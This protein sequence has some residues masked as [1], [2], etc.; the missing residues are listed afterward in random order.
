MKEHELL[1]AMLPEGLEPYFEIED[2]QKTEK[3][4]R[5]VLMEKNEVPSDLP[6]KFSS[7]KVINTLIKTITVDDFPVRGRKGELIF[8]RRAFSVEEI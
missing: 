4:F 3:T 1:W 7:K 5:I 6:D 2:F 8:K